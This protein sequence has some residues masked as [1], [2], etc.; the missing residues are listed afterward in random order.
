MSR[1]FDRLHRRH[2][3]FQNA[4]LAMTPQSTGETLTL[5][6]LQ[7]LKF[8]KEEQLVSDQSKN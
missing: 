7:M 8:Q 1:I 3:G 4:V 5:E 6:F 2:R